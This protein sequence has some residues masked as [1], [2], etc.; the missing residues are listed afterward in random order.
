MA[1]AAPPRKPESYR[2]G[3]GRAPNLELTPCVR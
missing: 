2:R 1:S 3:A